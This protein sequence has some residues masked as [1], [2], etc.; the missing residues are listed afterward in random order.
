MIYVSDVSTPL[1]PLG[2]AECKERFLG[3]WPGGALGPKW[4]ELRERIENLGPFTVAR[5]RPL[6]LRLS[7]FLFGGPRGRFSVDLSLAP[8]PLSSAIYRSLFRT[9]PGE[10]L[11]ALALAAEHRCA[12]GDVLAAI[13]ANPLLCVI[14]AHRVRLAGAPV[15]LP[16]QRAWADFLSNLPDERAEAH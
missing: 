15:C 7:A 11:T 3:V 8:G 5:E 12:E 4:R 14:P 16:E 2:V 10:T 6:G 9:R 13:H 1:G